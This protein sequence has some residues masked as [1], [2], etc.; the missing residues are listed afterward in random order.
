MVFA[1]TDRASG[2]GYAELGQTSARPRI[3]GAVRTICRAAVPG[4]FTTVRLPRESRVSL[5]TRCGGSIH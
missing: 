1:K 5:P 4:A 3:F 2:S